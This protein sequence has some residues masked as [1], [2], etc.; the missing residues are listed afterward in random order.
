MEMGFLGE[1]LDGTVERISGDTVVVVPRAGGERQSLLLDPETELFVSA[2]RRT[3]V[4][5]G[6]VIGALVGSVGAGALALFSERECS[7]A[8]PER[9]A[10]AHR[11]DDVQRSALVIGVGTLSGAILG[12]LVRHEVWKR[13][14]V[15]PKVLPGGGFGFSFA[16]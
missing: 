4:T 13:L 9:C 14:P 10:P 3:S 5:R 6:A 12:G 7:D 15:L 11:T 8:T 1:R 2:G 16:F